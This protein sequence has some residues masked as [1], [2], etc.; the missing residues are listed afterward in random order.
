MLSN[1]IQGTFQ[2]VDLYI[3]LTTYIHIYSIFSVKTDIWKYHP[4]PS[5]GKKNMN[6]HAQRG[7]PAYCRK[8]LHA[9]EA[10]SLKLGTMIIYIYI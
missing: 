3:Y 1:K 8:F 9:T 6:L 10:N 2:H 4:K 7:I 5:T